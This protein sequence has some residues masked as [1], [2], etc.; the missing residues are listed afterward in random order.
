MPEASINAFSSLSNLFEGSATSPGAYAL[1]LY[2]G[3]WAFD[4]WD[5][6]S[7]VAGEMKNVNR[8]LPRVIHVSLA[9]VVLIFL[10][11]VTSYFV[12][13]APSLVSR[14]NTVAL[15][16]GSAVFGTAGGLLFAFLVAFSCFGALNGS[17]YTS[18]RLVYVAGREGYLPA[19]FG[20]LNSRTRTPLAATVLQAVLIILFVLF[21]SG[22]ASLVN[23]YGVCSW[24]F[25]FVTVCGLLS[26]RIKEPNLERPYQ[27]RG[28]EAIL[29][30]FIHR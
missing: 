25:Y 26:L 10:S 24:F 2:S 30:V 23:F 27:V 28:D 7:Y 3:L 9:I 15:D 29:S 18:S 17:F 16:F 12:I 14:T 8:D 22:F 19:I 4:G 11:T 5:Q 21:G 1:A 20:R 13:L 6:T